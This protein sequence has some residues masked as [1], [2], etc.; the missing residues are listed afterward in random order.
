M[1]Y[2]LAALRK[3]E[4]ERRGVS[5]V[6]H[7]APQ[8]RVPYKTL[9]GTLFLLNAVLFAWLLLDPTNVPESTSASA[10]KKSD[11]HRFIKED[12]QSKSG[13]LLTSAI[14]KSQLTPP[15]VPAV[16]EVDPPPN[17]LEL[18]YYRD[19][20]GV[21]G[22]TFPNLAISIHTYTAEPSERTVHIGGTIWR[23]GDEIQDGMT[24]QA[25][26]ENGIEVS[27]DGYLVLLDVLELW[28]AVD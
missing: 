25:I 17:G 3:A 18:V 16:Q 22:Y 28:N 1:S 23:E 4:T 10:E 8:S 15:T 7:V 27:Y 14:S 20:E 26:T 24:L 21:V 19:F 9:V 12:L 13:E 5:L 2:I 6:D 11:Q